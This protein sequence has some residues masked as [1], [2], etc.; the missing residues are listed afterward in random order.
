MNRLWSTLTQVTPDQ[1]TIA[2]LWGLSGI[3]KSELVRQFCIK[4]KDDYDAIIW[5]NCSV[6]PSLMQSFRKAAEKLLACIL[7]ETPGCQEEETLR[8]LGL[9]RCDQAASTGQ[10]FTD[11]SCIA[12]VKD[13]LSRK[14]KRSL[15]ILDNWDDPVKL[16]LRSYI[17]D[18]LSNV[19]IIATSPTEIATFGV[20]IH[21]VGLDEQAANELLLHSTPN[22]GML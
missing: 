1:P 20:S 16:N 13:F 4:H 10:R 11:N 5:L 3:G 9:V 14:A 2:L 22:L 17:T 19:H 18:L 21:L 7:H 15:L 6:L 12:A 8:Y